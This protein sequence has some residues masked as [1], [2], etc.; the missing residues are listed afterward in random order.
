MNSHKLARRLFPES[1]AEIKESS[2]QDKHRLSRRL[3][4]DSVEDLGKSES[5]PS[6]PKFESIEHLD[7]WL[8]SKDP[9][10]HE[11]KKNVSEWMKNYNKNPS[12]NSDETLLY[13][14][15][16]HYKEILTNGF[17]NT[18]GHRSGFL[19]AVNQVKNQG[20]YLAND[21]QMAHFFGQNRAGAGSS[22]GLSNSHSSNDF[23]VIPVK[24]KLGNVLDLTQNANRMPASIKNKG[25]E[26]MRAY[27]GRK[28]NG[29][30][31]ADLIH[32]LDSPEFVQHLKNNKYDSV[33]FKETKG[34]KKDAQ[35]PNAFTHFVF[36]P[37][38]LTPHKPI[39]TKEDLFN[40]LNEHHGKIEEPM[41]KSEQDY[42]MYHTA[43]TSQSGAPMHN[44]VGGGIYPEDIYSSNAAHFYGDKSPYDHESISAIH[45]AKNFP[46]KPIK[47]YRAVPHTPSQEEQIFDLENQKKHILKHGKLPKHVKTNLNR[48]QYY[49]TIDDQINK[50]KSLPKQEQIKIKINPTDWVT[51]SKAYAHAHGK[52]HLNGQ[53]KI[54]S[55][56]VPAKHLYTSGDSIHEWGY[57]PSEAVQKSEKPFYHYNPKKNSKEGGL[58]DKYREKYNREH[59]SHLKRP[60]TGH[61]KAGS[62]A[63]NRRKSFCAR[64]SGVKGPTHKDGQLTPKGAALKRWNC[65]SV[66]KSELNKALLKNSKNGDIP[67][68]E[69]N[70][71]LNFK[72]TTIFNTMKD[73]NFEHF[74]EINDLQK[75]TKQYAA[76]LGDPSKHK[77]AF[78]TAKKMPNSNWGSW[79][80]RSYKK[81]PEQL[82]EIKPHLEHFA[83]SQHIP[84]IAQVRFD[85]HHDFNAGLEMLNN[86]QN[87]YEQ[88]I[89]SGK[90]VVKPSKG[91]EKILD[92]GNNMAWFSL[93]KPAC[94]AEGRAMGHCGND[95]SQKPYHDV[96]SLRTIHNIKGKEHHEPHATFI[97]DK[98]NGT[99]G[100]MKGRAN[101]KPIEKYH[102]HI[103][104]LF[105][106]TGYVPFGGGYTE[107]NNF[108]IDDL[109]PEL[110]QHVFK[111]NP[112]AFLMSSDPKLHNEALKHIDFDDSSL[113]D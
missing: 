71:G 112:A 104:K 17:K 6:L 47:I 23:K 11:H 25:L 98:D 32:L 83:G 40:A 99:V 14:G 64:M 89:S 100:E 38:R 72:K 43:P 54:L 61:P 107:E 75:S 65:G 44:V 30:Q 34:V 8:N 78:E 80:V 60:V 85:P 15:T 57:D 24:V 56:T 88:K 3:L 21:P 37:S 41:G 81:N 16:P 92:L 58:N 59:G 20:N 105:A 76:M 110:K 28:N 53:Y 33:K 103:A 108:H 4:E 69:K 46:N 79:V 63:A 87:Q 70:V 66:N 49:D 22:I 29:L 39:Q 26:I 62:E 48:S 31:N 13:H 52:A 90:N 5:G 113:E 97:L 18:N 9:S 86:A 35:T 1:L 19:G 42:K 106:H 96:L 109:S 27:D 45:S 67:S 95:P 51:P 68:F 73:S 102:P 82:K 50:I 94:T 7:D 93:G 77:E 91:T 101:Q 12:L 55:R 36:D 111:H 2:P 84:D 74:N 10:T